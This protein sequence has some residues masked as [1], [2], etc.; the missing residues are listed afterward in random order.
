MR[1]SRCPLASRRDYNEAVSEHPWIFGYGSLVWR[2]AFPFRQ[3]QPGFITGYARRFWQASTDHRGTPEAPG[4]VVTLR[5]EPGAVCWGMAYQVGAADADQVLR[6]LDYREKNGYRRVYTEVTLARSAEAGGVDTRCA[7]TGAAIQVQALVYIATEDN[8]HYLGPLP[9]AEIARV[10]RVSHGPSG[11]NLEYVLR[12][13]E[14]LAE[15]GAHDPHVAELA[16]LM[17]S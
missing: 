14:A 1:G 12:L 15:M 13:A 9:V 3:R 16:R 10:A 4:R 7:E 17:T 6:A 2:P 11:S 5:E 8:P